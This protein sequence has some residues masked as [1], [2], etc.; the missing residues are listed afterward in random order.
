MAKITIDRKLMEFALEALRFYADNCHEV[1]LTGFKDGQRIDWKS[2]RARLEKSCYSLSHESYNGHENFVEDGSRAQDALDAL[3]AAL[4][5]PA[6][7]E[8]PR[9]KGL[10]Q[11]LRGMADGFEHKTYWF[12]PYPIAMSTLL[13]QAAD[14]LDKENT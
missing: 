5:E 2:E 13:R 12:R 3:E 7:P 8:T 9:R 4:A 1:T 10:A 6:Q 11:A 14:E